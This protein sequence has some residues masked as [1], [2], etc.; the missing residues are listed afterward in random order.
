MCIKPHCHSTQG[1][2]IIW[3]EASTRQPYQV[4]RVNEPL[5]ADNHIVHDPNETRVKP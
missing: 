1:Q 5:D 2:P 4:Y 3:R